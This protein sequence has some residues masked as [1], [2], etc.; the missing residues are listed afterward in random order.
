[1]ST[2]EPGTKT[3]CERHR[4]GSRRLPRTATSTNGPLRDFHQSG[5]VKSRFVV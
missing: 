3:G 1:M 5:P 2:V 4:S